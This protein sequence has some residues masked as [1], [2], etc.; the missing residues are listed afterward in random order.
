M[1]MKNINL[2]KGIAFFTDG[3]ERLRITEDGRFI[4]NSLIEVDISDKEEVKKVFYALRDFS[5]KTTK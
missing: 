4:V 2:D 3:K 1:D 5:S